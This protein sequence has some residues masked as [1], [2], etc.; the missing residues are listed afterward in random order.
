[1]GTRGTR[2]LDDDGAA[3]I[4]AEYRILLGYKVDP[5]KAWQLIYNYFY[6]E[7]K[8]SDDEDVFWLSVAL[9]QW[10]NGIL[11]EEV[12]QKA[13]QCID[14]ESYLEVW[15]ESDSATYKKRKAVLTQLKEKLINEVNPPRKVP[16]CPTCYRQKTGFAIGD[17]FSYTHENGNISYVEVVRIRKEPVTELVPE[18]DY[19]SKA[20]F[21]LA[22]ARVTCPCADGVACPSLAGYTC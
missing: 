20:D 21:A 15:K 7:Y 19:K 13:L 14:D 10:Q 6:P 5:E 12:K 11:K 18:L 9:F 2:L 16:K 8:G 3:D 17:I 1:M 4:C 22:C